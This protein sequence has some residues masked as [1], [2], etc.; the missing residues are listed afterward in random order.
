LGENFKVS[1][2][3]ISDK[4]ALSQIDKQLQKYYN[5]NLPDASDKQIF[6]AL[7]HVA[8]DKMFEKRQK[9][10]KMCKKKDAKAVNYLCMEFLIGKTLRTSL[11]NLGLDKVFAKVLKSKHKDINSIYALEDDAGLG[12]GGLGRLASCFLD[13]LATLNYPVTG[14]CIRYDF[15]LFKQ[16]FVDGQQTELPDEWLS[17]GEV[18][19]VPRPDKA[20]TIRFGGYITER[21]ENNHLK[22]DY[23]DC[24]EVE[25]FPYDMMFSGYNSK[26][27]AV[28]RLWSAKSFNTFNTK[29]FSQGQYAQALQE[30]NEIELISK[31]LYPADD[32]M[33]GKSLRLRQQYFLASA[34][35]QSIVS[36]HK[37]RYKDLKLLPKFIAIHLND[38]HPVL[39][40]PELMRILMDENDFSWEDAWDIV[41]K[42]VSY[43]NHTILKES[44]ETWDEDLVS[45]LLPRIYCIIKEIDRRFRCELSFKGLSQDTIDNMAIVNNRRIKMTN[46]AVVASYKVNGVSKLHSSILKNELLKDFSNIYKNKFTNVTNGVTHRRWLCEANP[47]L[48]NL[49]ESLIGDNFI[50]DATDLKK[51]ANFKTDKNV[52]KK[53]AEIKYENKK[54]FANFVYETSGI[55]IDPSTRFDVQAKRIHEYKRQ[56][57]NV[58]YIIYL[59]AILKQDPNADITT[60]TFIFAGKA[61]SGYRRAKEIVYL[62]NELSSEIEKDEVISKKL[63]V[64]FV[65]N[66]SVT[67]AEKLM[68]ATDVSEQISL[69]GQEASGTGNMKAVLNG[70]IMICTADGANIEISDVCGKNSSFMFGMKADEVEKIWGKYNP[71]SYYEQNPKIKIVIDM[72]KKGFNGVSFEGLAN[73][74]LS[75]SDNGDPY[76]CLADFDSYVNAKEELDK[77]YRN[78]LAWHKQCLINISQMGYFSSDRSINDY[79][80]D[81]WSLKEID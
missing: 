22:I 67:I 3:K 57:L 31:V 43:T 70:G 7:A 51:L 54:D 14:H 10:S 25:A 35:M 56:L 60:Q 55:V 39:C 61:A 53:L 78:S 49:I 29:M 24:T 9:F 41:N 59:Y 16:K 4:E 76:M 8:I 27:V 69:A 65:E 44:L 63:K 81:I 12:N 26:N 42:T 37:R 34:A 72:L 19:Q 18:W 80:K 30:K 52:I 62:I 48:A 33:Q 46:L 71:N 79:S 38:T 1:I 74:L 40:V 66:Y 77:L 36:T 28:L 20:C 17:T 6:N 68:P 73:Y 64:V 50:K 15:G 5:I 11:F 45:R 32:H 58:L 75:T 13:S 47:R 2:K 21:M 23:H